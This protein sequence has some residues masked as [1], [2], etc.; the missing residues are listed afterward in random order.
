MKL[1]P[2][3]KCFRSRIILKIRFVYFL[4]DNWYYTK[5]NVRRSISALTNFLRFREN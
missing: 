4:S 2:K 1:A 3:L 5:Y